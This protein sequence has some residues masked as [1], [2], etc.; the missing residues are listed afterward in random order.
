[1]KASILI[2]GDPAHIKALHNA[3]RACRLHL[4]DG[5]KDEGVVLRYKSTQ[6]ARTALRKAREYILT[7]TKEQK[8]EVEFQTTS[9]RWANA[10]AV[11][12]LTQ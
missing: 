8:Y 3:V 6:N 12:T 10:I 4:S 11:I 2:T 7:D 1:M 5:N 9:L